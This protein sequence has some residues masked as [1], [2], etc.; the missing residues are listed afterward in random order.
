M[1]EIHCVKCKARMFDLESIGNVEGMVIRCYKCG[2][3]N[4]IKTLKVNKGVLPKGEIE[5]VA[6]IK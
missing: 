2:Y 6:L 3:D 5:A 4:K 1:V